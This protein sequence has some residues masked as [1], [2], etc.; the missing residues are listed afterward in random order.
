MSVERSQTHFATTHPLELEL[1]DPATDKE[2]SLFPQKDDAIRNRLIEDIRAT[3][4]S[5]WCRVN[6]ASCDPERMEGSLSSIKVNDTTQAAAFAVLYSGS[7]YGAKTQDAVGD[8]EVIYVFDLANAH[9]RHREFRE[10]VLQKQLGTVDL[11]KLIEP[12]GLRF[13]FSAKP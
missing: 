1:Y 7:G 10:D 13:V 4:D 9:L 5:D 8:A 12:A 11:E 3:A 6:N 2:E